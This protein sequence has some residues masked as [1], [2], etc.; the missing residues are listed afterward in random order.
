MWEERVVNQKHSDLPA[1]GAGHLRD[2]LSL[3]KLVL[4]G[5]ARSS[6]T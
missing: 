1:Y 2:V 4:I 5:I 3:H 6:T